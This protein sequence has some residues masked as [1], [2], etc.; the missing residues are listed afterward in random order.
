MSGANIRMSSD[1]KTHPRG[2]HEGEGSDS[3]IGLILGPEAL[4]TDNRT[5]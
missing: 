3:D 2:S 5:V 1:R 4:N